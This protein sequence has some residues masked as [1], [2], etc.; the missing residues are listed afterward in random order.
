MKLGSS[1]TSPWMSP[2]HLPGQAG[3]GVASATMQPRCLCSWDQIPAS[4]TRMLGR[5]IARFHFRPTHTTIMSPPVIGSPE[6]KGSRWIPTRIPVLFSWLCLLP[7][8]ILFTGTSFPDCPKNWLPASFFSF[9]L[10]GPSLNMQPPGNTMH[11]CLRLVSDTHWL[12]MMHV[13]CLGAWG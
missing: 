2:E 6:A 9:L 5:Q 11:G 1:V 3:A 13:G 10:P 7:G 12:R 4:K 8:G